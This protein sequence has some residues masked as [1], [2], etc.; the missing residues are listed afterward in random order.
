[1]FR[2]LHP[3]RVPVLLAGVLAVVLGGCVNDASDRLA[4]LPVLTTVPDGVEVI[5]RRSG[6]EIGGW[7]SVGPTA[8]VTYRVTNGDPSTVVEQLREIALDS[9][10]DLEPAGYVRGS[11]ETDVGLARL[12]ASNPAGTEEVIVTVW[13]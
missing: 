10:W 2:P 6:S 5:E 1:V 13:L 12:S 4:E 3:M 8:T 7:P 9:G 11:L